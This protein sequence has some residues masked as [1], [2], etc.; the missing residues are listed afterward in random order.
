[1]KKEDIEQELLRLQ[2]QQKQFLAT[3][4]SEIERLKA[5]LTHTE[6]VEELEVKVKQLELEKQLLRERLELTE[7]KLNQISQS[8]AA[9]EALRNVVRGQARTLDQQLQQFSSGMNQSLE[10][11]LLSLGNPTSPSSEPI[12]SSISIEQP[13]PPLQL[14]QESI[15]PNLDSITAPTPKKGFGRRLVGI[16]IK[17]KGKTVAV[18]ALPD[19]NPNPVTFSVPSYYAPPVAPTV[20]ASHPVLDEPKTTPK[21]PKKKSLVKKLVVNAVTLGI[22]GL[23]GFAGYNK[24]IVP[25]LPGPNEEVAGAS[26]IA[27]NQPTVDPYA[28][29]YADVPF[30]QTTWETKENFDL[31]FKLSVPTNTT[32]LVQPVGGT[33]VWYLRKNSYYLKLAIIDDTTDDLEQWWKA[34]QADYPGKVTRTTFKGLNSI[35]VEQTNKTDISGTMY[36]LSRR[37]YIM[38]IWIKDEP[39]STDDG[40][41][42]AKMKDSLTF[43][44]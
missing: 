18:S 16:F 35:M 40:Q 26:T 29:S 7:A 41:R 2:E 11:L 37:G 31:E 1:M 36:F 27:S 34:K 4:G 6:S 17:R 42:I 21:P 5:Q 38:Q 28:L 20:V 25:A 39:A 3:T 23:A 22:I 14:N 43:T 24:F 9:L 30:D 12:L 13:A 8:G 19:P 10:M 44:K 15:S 33:N 32:N